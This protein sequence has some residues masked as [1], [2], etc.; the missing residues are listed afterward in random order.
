MADGA[1]FFFADPTGYEPKAAAKNLNAETAQVLAEARS[2]LLA[3]EGP[4]TAAAVHGVLEAIVTKLGV[5]LGKVAQP[6]RVSVAGSGV[7]PPIDATL[8]I[9]GAETT[10]R[11]IDRAI[12]F[13]TAN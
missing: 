10:L 11:R 3:L 13:A 4:W 7:S 9:L 5:G 1:A 12:A 2:A 6:L 8:A